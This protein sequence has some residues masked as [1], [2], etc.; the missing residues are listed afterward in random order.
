M[1]APE[2]RSG[3]AP[4]DACARVRGLREAL[5]KYGKHLP[6]CRLGCAITRCDK[7]G[8]L[9]DL[10]RQ[11]R[12]YLNREQ[13]DAVKAG[14]WYCATCPGD[15]GGTGRRYFWESEL[16]KEPCDCGFDAALAATP[17]TPPRRAEGE[18]GEGHLFVADPAD[19]LTCNHCGEHA[20]THGAPWCICAAAGTCMGCLIDQTVQRDYGTAGLGY[21]HRAVSR[22][23]AASPEPS[24]APPTPTPPR[25]G[26]ETRED[27]MADGGER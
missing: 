11:E 19:E 27:E 13:F 12:G 17:P 1:T 3:E 21:L 7:C 4:D 26:A 14:D 10:V 6:S 18:A 25:A 2:P 16:A 22:P 5:E 8:G 23:R 15:R 24:A 20:L 9:L